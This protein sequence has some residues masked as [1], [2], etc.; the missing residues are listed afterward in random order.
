MTSSMSAQNFK[1]IYEKYKNLLFRISFTY[2]KNSEDTEDILQEA[3]I[4]RVYNAPVFENEEHEKR[5]LINVTVNLCKNHVKSFWHR[6]KTDVEDLTELAEATQWNLSSKE[7]NVFSEVMQLP[8][9]QK[10]AIYLHYYEGYTCK[11][12]AEMLGSRES[13]VKMRLK[14]GRELLKEN[15]EV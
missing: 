10:I 8:N 14:K 2:L 15:M 1:E 4:K 9:K 13:T 7:K 6:N 11:E 3:F 12:I 5:W